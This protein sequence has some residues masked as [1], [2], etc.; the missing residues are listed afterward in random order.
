MRECALTDSQIGGMGYQVGYLLA[1]EN[2]SLGLSVVA[3]CV[4]PWELP[5]ANWPESAT[6]L[7][8]PYIEIE[9]IC[10]NVDEHRRRVE[11]RVSDIEGLSLPSWSQA[12]ERDYHPWPDA[13]LRLDTAHLTAEESVLQVLQA[14][15]R[16]K[17][18]ST[19]C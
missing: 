18:A 3:D 12:C 14:V 19:I 2:L 13:N 8:L 5:R 15:S 7:N 6:N 1:R 16:A 11:G 10:S 17:R 9:V 4:N